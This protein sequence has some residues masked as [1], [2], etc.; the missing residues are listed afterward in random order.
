M[1]DEPYPRYRKA[2]VRSFLS[3]TLAAAVPSL[4]VIATMPQ[5]A[6][7]PEPGVIFADYHWLMMLAVPA[8][9][10]TFAF[11]FV[12]VAFRPSIGKRQ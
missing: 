9:V 4:L 6:W 12:I 7:S 8:F 1:G 2:V 11:A 3:A 10:V 5:T